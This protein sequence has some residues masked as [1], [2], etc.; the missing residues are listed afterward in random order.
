MNHRLIAAA[1]MML[2]C[3]LVWPAP[4]G[5]A[6]VNPT[7]SPQDRTIAECTEAI[8]ANPNDYVSYN[9]RGRAYLD[10]GLIDEA[11]ADYSKAIELKPDYAAAY[12]SR[13]WASQTR[14][15]WDAAIEDYTQ[16]IKFDPSYWAYNN[17]AGC[18][19]QKEQYDLAIADAT[20]AIELN[21]K[22]PNS[23][24]HLAHAYT[25]KHQYEDAIAAYRALIANCTD[26]KDIERAKE[27]IRTL[28][29]SA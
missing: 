21:P 17:R 11:I 24:F 8:T 4:P 26:P 20:K 9:R 13:G 25:K 6:A 18:N 22:R 27:S 16:S 2:A 3:W 28:G 5:Q 23:Y 15:K 14:K 1:L 10:K 29:G 12:F 7:A 19:I